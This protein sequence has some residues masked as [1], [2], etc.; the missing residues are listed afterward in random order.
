MLH[1]VNV[2]SF[3]ASA[4][5]LRQQRHPIGRNPPAGDS[6]MGASTQ[7]RRSPFAVISGS[8][9]PD[10]RLESGDANFFD[11]LHHP[12]RPQWVDTGSPVTNSA[13]SRDVERA[14]TC[15]NV[16]AR[17]ASRSGPFLF[18]RNVPPVLPLLQRISPLLRPCSAG[19]TLLR[20]TKTARQ[21]LP[22]ARFRRTSPV[23]SRRP[24]V[25]T[26]QRGQRAI[27]G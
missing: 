25:A 1:S 10:F 14:T 16:G 4:R 18:S 26:S 20:A 19:A 13:A 22:P 8:K 21:A 3:S 24:V 12:Q 6:R 7:I 5:V 17:L 9:F 15:T 11:F 27:G 23:H 2:Q